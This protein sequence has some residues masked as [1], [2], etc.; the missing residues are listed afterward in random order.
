MKKTII[1]NSLVNASGTFVYTT[2]VAWF[3]FNSEKIFGKGMNFLAPLFMLLV[4]IISASITGFLVLG[5]P[6][7]LYFDNHKKES[8]V[9]L[10]VTLAWLLVFS[11]VLALTLMA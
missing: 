10:L 9:M 3:L 4:L 2:L 5:K 1:W 6:A 7:Q 11:L 8:V